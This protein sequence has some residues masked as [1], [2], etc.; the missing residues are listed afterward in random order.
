MKT[1]SV[2]NANMNRKLMNKLELRASSLDQKYM[3]CPCWTVG[4]MDMESFTYDRRGK[5][6][7]VHYA[8]HPNGCERVSF[9][10]RWVNR[11]RR[12]AI[13][14]AEKQNKKLKRE[15]LQKEGA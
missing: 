2:K 3:E 1:E 9:F 6:R 12:K 14:F 5:L 4:R 7:A 8:Y 13:R 10:S 15:R 11:A